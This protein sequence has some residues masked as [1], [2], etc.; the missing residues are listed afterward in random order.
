MNPYCDIEIMKY[1]KSIKIYNELINNYELDNT[2]IG[3]DIQTSA[4][5]L[6]QP[7][8]SG[9]VHLVDSG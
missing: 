7:H 3:T 8:I 5:T 9:E 4:Q 6:L 1:G 2:T